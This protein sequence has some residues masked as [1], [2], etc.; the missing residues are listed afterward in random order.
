MYKYEFRVV[1]SSYS[2]SNADSLCNE[3]LYLDHDGLIHI[4]IDV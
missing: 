1:H 3:F 2:I 4:D